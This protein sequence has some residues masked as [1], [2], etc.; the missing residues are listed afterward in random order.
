MFEIVF[1]PIIAIAFN[2]HICAVNPADT[3]SVVEAMNPGVCA[4][5]KEEYKFN[6]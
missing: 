6:P 1:Y 4:A 2:A 5:R 3:A